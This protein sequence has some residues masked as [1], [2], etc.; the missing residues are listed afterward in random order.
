MIDYLLNQML[1]YKIH[2]KDM[3]L[4]IMRND[5]AHTSTAYLKSSLSTQW[6]SKETHV[7]ACAATAEQFFALT[8]SS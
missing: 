7:C 2:Q 5:G 8:A 4:P 6:Y 1:C 3:C